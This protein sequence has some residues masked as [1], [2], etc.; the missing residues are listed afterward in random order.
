MCASDLS[1][2]RQRQAIADLRHQTRALPA[3]GIRRIG[4]GIGLRSAGGTNL[5]K[6]LEWYFN[7][8]A[9]VSNLRRDRV[10]YGAMLM[11]S[12]LPDDDFEPFVAATVL[13]LLERLSLPGSADDGFWNWNRLAP[14]Y[15]L[16]PAATRAAIMNGFR[17]ASRQ[18]R[19]ALKGGP[20]AA[21]C[22][23]A[24][25]EAV[26]SDLSQAPDHP[27]LRVVHDAVHADPD[28]V[29]A[30]ALWAE[31]HRDVANLPDVQRRAAEIGVR[32]LYERPASIAPPPGRDVAVLPVHD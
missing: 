9:P 8:K 26:L 1:D 13:L 17:E 12:A 6:R 18:G 2:F 32:H 5:Q 23:T 22:L 30:G 29:Q 15:R 20:S 14:H 21:D 28:A 3:V 16:A 11:A 4:A 19:I 7:G 24:P 31:I 25:R 10:V 27:L